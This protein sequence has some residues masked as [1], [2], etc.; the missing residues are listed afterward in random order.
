[1]QEIGR[2]ID[3]RV[4]L[5]VGVLSIGFPNFK[6]KIAEEYLKK[7]LE[8]MEQK[9]VELLCGKRTLVTEEE[10]N[11]EADRLASAGVDLL[12][13]QNGTY[14]HGTCMMHIITTFR[15]TPILLWGFTEPLIEGFTGL[16]LN[17]LCGLNMFGS[18]LHKVGKTYS[19][20]YGDVDD[21]KVYEKVRLTFVAL[22]V[23]KQLKQSKFCV[24]GGRAPGFYLSSADEIRLRHE[25]GPEIVHYSL[26]SLLSDMEKL[27]EEEVREEKRKMDGEVFLVTSTGKMM[28]R[29][30]RI[31][32]AVKGFQKKHNIDGFAIKCWPEFQELAN[33]SVCGVVSRL[34][35]DGTMTSCEGD[36]TGLLSMYIQ[37]LVTNKNCFFADLV[38]INP[39]G[40]VKAWH[41]GPA[42]LSLT[43]DFASTKYTEHPTI[44]QGMGIALDFK[45]M[46]GPVLMLKMKEET[47]GY[48]VFMAKGEAVEEDRVVD[49][50]QTDI[51]FE[52]GAE[53][54]LDAVMQHGIEHHY[55]VVYADIREELKELSKW[56]DFNVVQP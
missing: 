38:N 41:C 10:I 2:N 27:P 39:N 4:P 42:P 55:A 24:I 7:T 32:L 48:T 33:C 16:P 9:G 17:S 1:M 54:F 52:V 37:Y 25:V 56:M 19:Y 6:Y 3:K 43:R 35:N 12:V 5:L 50:N 30:A 26:A 36:V 23:K 53:A 46:L 45:M 49:A 15:D 44:R 51:R 14:S 21:A 18:F 13:V 22:Q 8:R 20:V 47:K 28:E 31:Y 34:N 29:T 40:T 11:A